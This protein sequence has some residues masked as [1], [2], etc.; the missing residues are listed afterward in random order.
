M[1]KV[2]FYKIVFLI[3]FWVFCGIFITV[4]D[5][6]VMNFKSGIGTENY[7]FLR[8]LIVVIIVCAI[9]AS[10]LGSVE[11][12]CLSRLLRK[13]A[14]GLTLVIKTTIYIM[15]M[16]FLSLWVFFIFTVPKS[17]NRC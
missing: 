4:Y 13:T 2:Q 9:G 14:F 8:N 11:V 3:S 7:S 1:G 17:I 15:F 10:L 16:L 6:S 12:L 5:A